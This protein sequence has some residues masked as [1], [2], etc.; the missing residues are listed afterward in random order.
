[1]LR[2]AAP[3]RPAVGSMASLKSPIVYDSILRYHS[4]QRLRAGFISFLQNPYVVDFMEQM[5]S[6][7][8]FV[9]TNLNLRNTDVVLN[10]LVQFSREN[11][12]MIKLY[13][14]HIENGRQIHENI[15][16]LVPVEYTP[17]QYDGRVLRV[18][19]LTDDFTTG[20][21]FDQLILDEYF[22]VAQF[23]SFIKLHDSCPKSIPVPTTKDDR[24]YVYHIEKNGEVEPHVIVKN[25]K[26]GI[27]LEILILA[28][29]EY[30]RCLPC[31][32]F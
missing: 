19:I 29:S 30:E 28:S 15:E 9:P 16:R 5:G 7:K 31:W 22:P 18:R 17:I 12:K 32:N 8:D 1:M 21:L 13:H 4:D 11:T 20:I 24:L 14:Q 6:M 10:K 3:P 27:E 25:N 26:N 23:Q 2:Q